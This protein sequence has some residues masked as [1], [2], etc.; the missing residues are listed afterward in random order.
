MDSW[1]GSL[2]LGSHPQTEPCPATGCSSLEDCPRGCRPALAGRRWA[3]C[4][5][6][7]VSPARLHLHPRGRP[8]HT[9][10]GR[11]AGC[12]ALSV[13]LPAGLRGHSWGQ[14][15]G[16]HAGDLRE[17]QGGLG[18]PSAPADLAAPAGGKSRE[19]QT[20][21]RIP[22][23]ALPPLSAPQFPMSLLPGECGRHPSPPASSAHPTPALG[24]GP[25]DQGQRG[26]RTGRVSV[27]I[28]AGWALP[29]ALGRVTAVHPPPAS[30]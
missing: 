21:P 23:P 3:V 13:G 18:A 14:G 2:A 25:G 29:H 7:G 17:V 5:E 22:A 16:R 12:T 11:W 15:R 30:A 8:P 19:G 4:G 24:L 26:A 20:R 1:A 9:S 28:P 6:G 10:H 27:P